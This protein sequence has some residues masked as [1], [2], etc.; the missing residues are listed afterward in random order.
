M[1]RTFLTI[2]FISIAS[3]AIHAQG[4][5]RIQLAKLMSMTSADN[6][7]EAFAHIDRIFPVITIKKASTPFHFEKATREL[8][9]VTYQW[10]GNTSSVLEFI[11]K[12]KTTSFIAIKD[13]VIVCE[14]YFQGYSS[15]S[16]PTSMSVAKSFVSALIGIA[17]GEGRIKSIDD[18]ITEYVPE[19][20]KSG[21][22]GVPIR[23]ILQM[24]SGINFVEVY[25][26]AKSDLM[27]MMIQLAGGRSLIEYAASLASRKPS[28]QEF[29]YASIDTAVLGL[30]L[31]RVTG[32]S[33][34]A[35]LEDKIWKRI[36]TEA[37]ASWATDNHGN[38][39]AFAW[40]N[41]T[42]LDFA[43]FGRLYLNEGR[44]DGVQIVPAD[45]IRNS[46]VPSEK[47]LQPRAL[48]GPDWNIGYQFQ[49][50]VPS[51]EEKEFV[52]I[53]I[54]GQFIYVNPTRKTI[55]VKTSVDP[56]FDAHE[57]E[58]IEVF[59]SVVNAIGTQE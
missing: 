10:R 40:L 30:L 45:W 57:M 43:R 48:Y 19:L 14:M 9:G 36:G 7:A 44:W 16:M 34:A 12:T 42:P 31:E 8:D 23:H 2:A 6:R 3:A 21:Y 1:K 33:A 58:T 26:D 56:L 4:L 37:D 13:D 35:Y 24:S 54:W 46:V 41:A 28:G 27:T 49:W 29:N 59:K 20:S 52:A 55:I 50:W 51:G 38:P 53:G 22:K 17:V 15:E 11:E 39:L 32:K 47:H 5:D 25:D 18:A